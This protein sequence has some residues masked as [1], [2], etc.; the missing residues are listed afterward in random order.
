MIAHIT[1]HDAIIQIL[2]A[3]AG[4]SIVIIIMLADHWIWVRSKNEAKF[5]YTG[6]LCGFRLLFRK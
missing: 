6:P 5:E 4:S 3:A 2:G 1:S